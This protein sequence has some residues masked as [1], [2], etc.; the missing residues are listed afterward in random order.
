MH[1][2]TGGWGVEALGAGSMPEITEDNLTEAA[3]RVRALIT[4]RLELLWQQVDQHVSEVRAGER[5]Q[6]PRML[7]IGKGI[8]KELAGIYR[9]GKPAPVA[10][11]EDEVP[12]GR[13]E[14]VARLHG[15]LDELEAKRQARTQDQ[16]QAS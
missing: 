10:E 4:Q 16:D 5:V 1:V 13:D 12:A 15:R 6:D 11:V 7:E 14:L 2:G 3:P 9:L 8:L